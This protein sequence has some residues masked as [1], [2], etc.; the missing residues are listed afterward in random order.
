MDNYIREISEILYNVYMTFIDEIRVERLMDITN[1]A[2]MNFILSIEMDMKNRP[3]KIK[4]H[5]YIGGSKIEIFTNKHCK[6]FESLDSSIIESIL[7]QCIEFDIKKTDYKIT[8]SGQPINDNITELFL[9]SIKKKPHLHLIKN[10]CGESTNIFTAIL[11]FLIFK[12]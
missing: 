4:Y 8:L 3:L 12:K 11:Q 2:N 1:V 10:L 7:T 5:S 6:F 9:N